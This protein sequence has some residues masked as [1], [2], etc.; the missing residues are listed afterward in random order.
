MSTFFSLVTELETLL[1]Q[2]NTILSGSENETVEVNGVS[3]DSISKAINDNFNAL[4]AMVQ[5]RVTFKTLPDMNANLAYEE[6][7]LAE[8]WDDEIPENNGLYGKE[9]E[10]GSGIWKRSKYDTLLSVTKANFLESLIHTLQNSLSEIKND[11]LLSSQF[12]WAVTDENNEVALGVNHEGLVD[13]IPSE[14]TKKKLT[15]GIFDERNIE[16]NFVWGVVSES[17]TMALAIDRNGKTHLVRH[18]EIDSENVFSKSL[19][20]GITDDQGRVALGINSSGN[21]TAN[22][23]DESISKVAEKLKNANSLIEFVDNRYGNKD[24]VY[25]HDIDNETTIS[26]PKNGVVDMI[27]HAGQSLSV[28]GGAIYYLNNDIHSQATV[29]KTAAYPEFCLMLNDGARGNEWKTVD[30]SAITH[31]KAIKEEFDNSRV[32]ETQGSGMLTQL[33][34]RLSDEGNLDHTWL[35]RTHG[36]G[37]RSY[38]EIKKGT[39]PYA[40]A[41][42]EI[43][44][45]KKICESYGWRLRVKHLFITHGEDDAGINNQDYDNNLLEFINDY[46]TDIPAI[47]EQEEPVS[48]FI[49][50]KPTPRNGIG[51]KVMADQLNVALQTENCYLT[52]PKYQYPFVDVVHLTA[53]GYRL[54]GEKQGAVLKRVLSGE[55]WL[56]LHPLS[57]VLSDNE[58]IVTFHVPVPPL[59]LDTYL[60]EPS[61]NYGFKYKDSTNSAD[62]QT[63]EVIDSTKVK[64]TLNKAPTG[65]TKKITYAYD[66]PAGNLRDSETTVAE[67]DGSLLPNWAIA[68]EQLI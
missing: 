57:A 29:S 1:A 67:F 59:I 64:I 44:A 52:Q 13:F 18:N 6:N 25:V 14:S 63:V 66:M 43:L 37:G 47:T 19:V 23:D 7:T 50:Q 5:G 20:W 12:V 39:I 51:H 10:S 8:V 28:G 60:L 22:L 3:K 16:T 27:I 49:D 68:F 48:V 24:K 56:P 35:Y 42:N 45:A 32:G 11:D 36:A 15:T 21:V 26:R 41:I 65:D 58:I 33:H 55:D 54:C 17:N 31:F 9:G 40:N 30:T 53:G 34:K 2:L 46:R 62:I 4:Q 61:V 38:E